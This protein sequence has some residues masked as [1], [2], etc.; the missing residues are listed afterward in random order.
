M[1][2]WTKHY[3]LD[4]TARVKVDGTLSQQVRIKEGVPQGGVI[5]PTLF[6]V[7]IDEITKCVPQQVSNSL[8]ADDFAVW[9][10]SE[11]TATARYR[12][13]ET[14]NNVRSWTQKWGLTKP[15]EDEI[16]RDDTPTFLGVKLDCRLTWKPH[17]DGV[18]TRAIRR[19]A[20]IKK[21]C[22]N[23][24]GCNRSCSKA[25]LQRIHQTS[26]GICLNVMVNICCKQQSQG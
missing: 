13:Q 21:K 23:F 4:R 1:Y 24:L 10:S 3:L 20:L 19:L 12:L 14:V 16:P 22:R 11:Y 26:H 25:G 7:Y 9:S 17:I 18:R 8:H 2:W 15:G 5:S 6:L